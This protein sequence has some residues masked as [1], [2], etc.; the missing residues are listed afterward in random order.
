MNEFDLLK[1]AYRNSYKPYYPEAIEYRVG[2]GVAIA[3]LLSIYTLDYL[4]LNLPSWGEFLM[5]VIMIVGYGFAFISL[6]LSRHAG[7]VII[8][9]HRIALKPKK[10]PEKYPSSPIYVNEETEINIYLMKS[11]QFGIQRTLLHLQV[12]NGNKES[13]FGMLLKNKQKHQQ[14]YD[15]LVSWYKA[16]F[17]VNE[18]DQLGSRIFKLNEGK[19]YED[20]QRIKREYGLEWK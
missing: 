1:P 19:N 9:P 4:D 6:F 18:F 15:V 3:V 12:I 5:G 10:N 14:Y 7:K 11:I 17:N 20:V 13:D 2:M 16:G 8:S